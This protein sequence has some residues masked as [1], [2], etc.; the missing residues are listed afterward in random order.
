MAFFKEFPFTRYY[1][2]DLAWLIKR[3]RE[4][5]ERFDEL[6][7]AIEEMHQLKNEILELMTRLEQI[8][9]E[10]AERVI[11]EE[12]GKYLPQ[13]AR[14][15]SGYATINDTKSKMSYGS[16]GWRVNNNFNSGGFQIS[17]S[18]TAYLIAYETYDRYLLLWEFPA[19]GTG[20]TSSGSCDLSL[21]GTKAAEFNDTFKIDWTEPPAIY[22]NINPSRYITNERLVKNTSDQTLGYIS[23]AAQLNPFYG[24]VKQFMMSVKKANEGWTN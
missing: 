2:T 3:M 22:G 20:N 9:Q 1:D 24:T 10:I 5:W 19:T 6:D 17:T 7:K 14:P 12:I 18:G 16:N 4:L 21:T 11:R 23:C 13:N 15:I 8:V